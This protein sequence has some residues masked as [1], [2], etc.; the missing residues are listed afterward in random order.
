MAIASNLYRII[1]EARDAGFQ[2]AIRAAEGELK[3]LGSTGK[4]AG[5]D[6]DK[7][8]NVAQAGLKAVRNELLR[9]AGGGSVLLILRSVTNSFDEMAKAAQRAGVTVEKLSALKYAADLSGVSFENLQTGVQQFGQRL[10]ESATGTDKASKLLRA[11]G[12]DASKGTLPALKQLAD[13]FAST[14][15]GAAKTALAAELLGQD[16]G[17]KLIPLLNAGASGINQMM[18][19]AHQLGL[20]MDT[21]TAKA[22]ERLNDDITRLTGSFRGLTYFLAGPVIAGLANVSQL[23]L[24]AIKN[25][26]LLSTVI[27]H[28]SASFSGLTKNARLDQI[29]QQIATVKGAIAD[30]QDKG[31]TGFYLRARSETLNALKGAAGLDTETVGQQVDQLKGRLKDLEAERDAVI[32]QEH[33]ATAAASGHAS[34][35]EKLIGS[36]GRTATAHKAVGSAAK[37]SAREQQTA[38]KALIAGGQALAA[39]MQHQRDQIRLMQLTGVERARASAQ[40]EVEAKEHDLNAKALEA[41]NAGHRKLADAYRQQITAWQQALPAIQQNAARLYDLQS[42]AVSTSEGV[43]EAWKRALKGIDTGFADLWKS[44]F[45]GG[46]DMLDNL[47]NAILDFLAEMAH[48]LIT[49]PLAVSLTTALTG[50][51]ASGTAAA[52]TAGS[53]GVGGTGGIGVLGSLGNLLSGT[54]IGG[55]I[56]S[57]LFN[58]GSAVGIAPDTLANGLSGIANTSNLVYGISGIAGAVVGHLLAQ[59]Q[60]GQIGSAVGGIAGSLGGA[61]LAGAISSAAGVAAGSAT[62]AAIGSVV[63]VVGTI[64][65]A[66]IGAL[67][68]NAFGRPHIPEATIAGR[69]GGAVPVSGYNLSQEQFQQAINS[70]DAVNQLVNLISSTLG[71]SGKAAIAGVNI[72][73]TKGAPGDLEQELKNLLQADIQAAAAA[74]EQE[75]KFIA[76]QLGDFSGSLQDTAKAIGQAI[77]DFAGLQ[78]FISDL[79]DLGKSLG[80]TDDAVLAAAQHMADLAGSVSGLANAQAFYYQNFYSQTEQ[81][82]KTYQDAENVIVAWNQ[83]MGRTGDAL[84]DTKQ[85]LRAFVDSLDLTTEAGQAA[86]VQALAIAPAFVAASDAMAKLTGSTADL[87]GGLSSAQTKIQEFLTGLFTSSESPL[88]PKDQLAYARTQF[89]QT[90]SAAQGGDQAA[91]SSLTD[92]AKTYLDEAR[93]YFGSSTGYADVFSRITDEL[94]TLIPSQ[95]D[96]GAEQLT[97]MQTS[98]NVERAGFEAVR[99]EIAA[100]RRDLD[101]LRSASLP[102]QAERKVA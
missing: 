75:A 51:T 2:A 27:D 42:A 68:G 34:A 77:Q 25:G 10:A 35:L 60:A 22:A 18:R 46:T 100:L 49:H 40:I 86:Y 30:L 45:R 93:Q 39:Y 24:D 54:S 90:Y 87:A 72:P 64:I 98:V 33:T 11:L 91:L 5:R 38:D 48:L 80:A 67:A 28:L 7:G 44:V 19:E 1:L 96:L 84:I 69:Q 83:G 41:E 81:L 12:I 62:G 43:A 52:A 58:L 102:A 79:A 32:K 15:D 59:N 78:Q 61:S 53:A 36:L 47:K 16:L 101:A 37:S 65:G 82:Q 95:Q 3:H 74:G 23:F 76:Q 20:E 57:G 94:Q 56:A 66:A 29:A 8:L 4:A 70:I 17:P 89:E 9:L 85:E 50:T 31:I 13:V 71:E 26:S 73:P 97:A 92:V 14:K 88:S 63:P 6:L 99:A 55:G 21:Q